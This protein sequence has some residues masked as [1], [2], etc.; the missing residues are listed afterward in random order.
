MSFLVV[1][2][3]WGKFNLFGCPSCMQP[4]ISFMFVDLVWWMLLFFMI[5]GFLV[6]FVID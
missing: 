3:L 5:V 6:V 2:N 1:L 4:F